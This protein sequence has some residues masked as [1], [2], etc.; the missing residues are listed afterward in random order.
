MIARRM[1]G[2]TARCLTRLYAAAR[3]DGG[4]FGQNKNGA[5]VPRIA[6][7]PCLPVR[8]TV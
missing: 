4:D 2:S 5:R 6:G 3:G 1:A 7:N 8:H